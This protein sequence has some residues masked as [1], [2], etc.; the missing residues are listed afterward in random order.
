MQFLW[1]ALVES[2]VFAERVRVAEEYLLPFALN[3][4]AR[5]SI[6]KSAQ[7]VLRHKG[8]ISIDGLA[9]HTALSV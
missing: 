2:K 8:A 6:M 7:H 9:N 3:A 1:L 4:L 5:T